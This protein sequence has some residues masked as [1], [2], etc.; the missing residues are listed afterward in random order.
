MKRGIA[1]DSTGWIILG[2]LAVLVVI[3]IILL[4]RGPASEL[5]TEAFDRLRFF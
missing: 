3:G 2:I 5:L 1:L 4:L